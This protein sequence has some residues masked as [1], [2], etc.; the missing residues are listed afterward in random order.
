MQGKEYYINIL[1]GVFVQQFDI[2]NDYLADNDIMLCI[3]NFK[4]AITQQNIVS[5]W[6]TLTK[7]IAVYD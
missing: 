6:S 2:P 5:G 4:W 3:Y 1:R 7:N